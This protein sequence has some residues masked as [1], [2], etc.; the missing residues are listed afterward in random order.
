MTTILNE[1][2]ERVLSTKTLQEKLELSFWLHFELVSVHPFG[3][4]NGRTSRLLMNFVQ[5][6]FN[7]PLGVVYKND[8]LHYFAALEKTR[9]TGNINV[10]YEFMF[11]QYKKFLETEVEKAD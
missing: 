10:F 4:G 11:S 5:E 7:L 6:Y 9:T 1:F 2:N 8:K 3:D